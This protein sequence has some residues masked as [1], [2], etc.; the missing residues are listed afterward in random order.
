MKK[1]TYT[2]Y[3]ALRRMLRLSSK[4][5]NYMI[6]ILVLSILTAIMETGYME[7]IRRLVNGAVETNVGMVYSGAILG[8]GIIVIRFVIAAFASRMSALLNNVS[9]THLQWTMLEKLSKISMP[10]IQ[11]VH[12]GDLTS[13]VWDSAR[14]AQFGINDKLL[15]MLQSVIQLGIAFLYFSWIN[16]PLSLGV[17]GYTIFFSFI[18]V[19]ISRV[20]R[21]RYDER[22]AAAADR[23]SFLTD[24]VHASEEIRTYALG[25]YVRTKFEQKM[26]RVFAAALR[27]SIIER[28]LDASGRLSTFGGMIFILYVGG[29]QVYGG[30]M[31]VGGL[32]T[33]LVASSQLTRPVESLSGIWAGLMGAISQADRVFTIL[34]QPSK[35]ESD[36]SIATDSISGGVSVERV[37]FTYPHAEESTLTNLSFAATSG[38]MTVIT[39]PSGCGKTT[40]L[41]ILTGGYAADEGNVYMAGNR[42]YV[43]QEAFILSGTFRENI[44]FGCDGATEEQWIAAAKRASIHD[45]IMEHPNGYDTLIGDQ[46]VPLSGGEKQRITLARAFLRNPSVLVLDEPTSSLD[47]VHERQVIQA[48]QECAARMTVIVVTH[49]LPLIQ[50]ADHVVFM[51]RGR[52]VDAGSHEEL[53]RRRSEYDR[54]MMEHD[55]RVEEWV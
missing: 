4:H 15:S 37:S 49:R 46:G 5:W 48:L 18:A 45:R 55:G 53:L 30:H 14:E 2:S 29:L 6:G 35:N 28:L 24:T 13:R 33:F 36:P 39:G 40:L 44:L 38:R 7:S 26:N 20:L 52:I 51:E 16:I 23:D 43:P 32:A 8:A 27:V 22:N 12:S 9:V 3:A 25:S 47:P 50:L 11:Q 19:P 54:F 1:Q 17:I 42:T 10:T 41:Q 34:D 31:D 21:R